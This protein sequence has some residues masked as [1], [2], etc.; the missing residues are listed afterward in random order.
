MATS[1]ELYS[2]RD[3]GGN[4]ADMAQAMGGWS[5]KVENPSD[6]AAAIRR[7][8]SATEN[9]QASLLE[10]ITSEESDFSHRAPFS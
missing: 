1:H 7:A 5:E 6:V 4:Y 10:F 3:I 9:G 2:T 8:R